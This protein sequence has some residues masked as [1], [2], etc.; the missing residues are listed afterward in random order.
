MNPVHVLGTG[1][2]PED[3]TARHLELLKKAEILVGGARHLSWFAG[4]PGQKVEIRA[5]LSRVIETVK[6]AARGKRVVVLA[7]GDPLF[8]GIGHTLIKALGAENVLI[9]P[10]VPIIAAAFARLGMPWHGVRTASLHGRGGERDF[11]AALFAGGPVFA[12]TDPS[13][14]PAHVARLVLGHAPGLF[15]M[16][17][18]ERMG[19][20][21]E[22]VVRLSPEE[23]AET[24]F[25]EPNAVAVL[26]L[27]GAGRPPRPVLGAPEEAYAHERGMIT[28][29]EV[30][31]VSLA[32]LRLGPESV[33]W[34]LGAGSGSVAVEAALWITRGRILAVEKNPERIQ[35]IRENMSRHGAWNVEAVEAALPAGME[36]LPDPDRVFLGGGGNDLPEI[37]A[38]AASRLAPGGRMVVNAVVTETFVRALDVLRSL[39]MAPDTVQISVAEGRDIAGGLRFEAKNPV[40]VVSAEKRL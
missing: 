12:L 19:E 10:N 7:S 5:P 26:P 1:T 4:H 9:H 20:P 11:L 29:P 15:S 40:W 37:L 2:A 8:F 28:K 39:G 23:A 27:E 38:R 14:E 3:L 34:D 36:A 31:A 32:R 18:F 24:R 16:A 35:N 30:R 25:E 21:E 22:R 33:L 17:V 6:E 13:R